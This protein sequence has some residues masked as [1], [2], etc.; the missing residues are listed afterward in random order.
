MQMGEVHLASVHTGSEHILHHCIDLYCILL[1]L[2]DSSL[3]AIRMFVPAR[4]V[5]EEAGTVESLIPMIIV[6]TTASVV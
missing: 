6:S 5:L 2:S 1:G 4:R 3:I